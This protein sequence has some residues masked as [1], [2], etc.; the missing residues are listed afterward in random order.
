MSVIIITATYDGYQL[1]RLGQ[2]AGWWGP[3]SESNQRQRE[4]QRYKDFCNSPV[5][6]TGNR[7]S[8]LSKQIDHALKYIDLI[9]AF[10]ARWN[11]GR[12]A[13]NSLQQL[14]NT[15]KKLKEQYNSECTGKGKC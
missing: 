15:M 5:P 11:P 1:N 3:S 6:D 4:Y 2:A 13:N 7:C 12:H 8:D 9:E 10:D 14:Q